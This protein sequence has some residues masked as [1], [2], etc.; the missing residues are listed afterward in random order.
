RRAVCRL[1]SPEKKPDFAASPDGSTLAVLIGCETPIY[2]TLDQLFHRVLGRPKVV[3][4]HW[5]I[6]LFDTRTGAERAVFSQGEEGQLLGFGPDGRTL[7][8]AA[9]VPAAAG[10]GA[11]VCVIR[12]WVA[13]SPW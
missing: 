8:T 6:Q 5:L 7:W 2:S 4:R 11:G 10:S 9:H 12:G 1:R 3:P 13:P